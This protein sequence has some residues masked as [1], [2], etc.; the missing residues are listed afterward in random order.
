MSKREEFEKHLEVNPYDFATRLVFSD[1]L[2]QEGF[3][4]EAVEERRKA[5]DKWMNAREYFRHL[6]EEFMRGWG[7]FGIDKAYGWEGR[8][9][10]E[11]RSMFSIDGLIKAARGY[12]HN[13]MEGWLF[14]P[15]D[16]PDIINS[17]FWENYEIYTGEQLG[18]SRNV[19]WR[20]FSCGC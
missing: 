16:T 10:E 15:F 17:D 5:T 8:D 4:D 7:R 20:P 14:T 2:E 13:R 19:L 6:S 1:W 11:T 3:D 9:P 12:L 18:P